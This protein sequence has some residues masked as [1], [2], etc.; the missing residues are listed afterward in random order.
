MVGASVAAGVL[1]GEA[2]VVGI[3]SSHTMIF[4]FPIVNITLQ[5]ALESKQAIRL[6]TL[7]SI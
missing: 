6:I 4:L 7:Q 3:V 1:V 5:D 2:V